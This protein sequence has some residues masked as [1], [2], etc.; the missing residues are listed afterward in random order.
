MSIQFIKKLFAK[1]HEVK[2]VVT[3]QNITVMV[4][5][6]PNPFTMSSDHYLANQLKE[7]INAKDTNG[8][9]SIIAMAEKASLESKGNI[10]VKNGVVYYK[11][12]VCHNVVADRLLQFMAYGIDVSNLTRFLDRVMSNPLK[13]AQQELFLFLENGQLPIMAD[14]RF[15]A[16]K[17]VRDDYFDKHSGTYLN[18]VG[19]IIS[20][21]RDKCDTNRAQACSAGL[22]VCTQKYTAFAER[23]LLV[24]VAPEDVVSVPNDYSNAKMRCCKYEVLEELD[25]KT[26]GT[27]PQKAFVPEP[28]RKLYG[29]TEKQFAVVKKAVKQKKAVRSLK[30]VSR[31]KYESIT[32]LIKLAKEELKNE[33]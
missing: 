19:S 8:I 15:Q 9:L 29:L 7:Y 30:E 4:E 10:A 17:W 3:S 32:N 33:R 2:K 11:G 6:R 23:L 18:K 1:E 20:M 16:Y 27:I 22:H 31:L 13:S 25:P 24:A 21:E 12:E 26:Y 5:G 28:P 14:G